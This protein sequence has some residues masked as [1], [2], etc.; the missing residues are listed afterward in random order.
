M[1]YGLIS[2]AVTRDFE[3][4]PSSYH[5][6]Q[7]CCGYWWKGKM[8]YVREIQSH[9]G[10]DLQNQ[11]PLVCTHA[12]W[13]WLWYFVVTD[14]SKNSPTEMKSPCSGS[15]WGYELIWCSRSWV[16]GCSEI[17]IWDIQ[18]DTR[19]IRSG[20]LFVSVGLN[21]ALLFVPVSRDS[22]LIS[23]H[24]F[25]LNFYFW[26]VCVSVCVCSL[27]FEDVSVDQPDTKCLDTSP[28]HLLC[29][30][31]PGLTKHEI[32]QQVCTIW[33]TNSS[34]CFIAWGSFHNCNML[35]VPLIVT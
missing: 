8:F 19:I 20:C 15:L 6:A 13:M 14:A 17:N 33:W 7:S 12:S 1:Q 32:T 23:P 27:I 28:T 30:S 22:V 34:L 2:L 29:L 11:I 18:R 3:C 26:H 35:Q 25:S 5:I 21:T 31:S 16:P 24:I 10:Q 9:P 4:L